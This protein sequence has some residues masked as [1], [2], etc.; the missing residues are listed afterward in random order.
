MQGTRAVWT[1]RAETRS[2][3][4]LE[5]RQDLTNKT[6]VNVDDELQR[7]LLVQ[8]TYSA[9]VQVIKAASSMLDE[10]TQIR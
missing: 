1:D 7:L 8:Q 10:L 5:A 2:S 3:L 6:A 9:S 4:A